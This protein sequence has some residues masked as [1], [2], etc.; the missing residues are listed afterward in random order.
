[1]RRIFAGPVNPTWA[2]FTRD[3]ASCVWASQPSRS[4]AV[5]CW[6]SRRQANTGSGAFRYE[7]M[8]HVSHGVVQGFH[9]IARPEAEQPFALGRVDEEPALAHLH[10]AGGEIRLASA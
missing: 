8:L 6:C 9:W 10:V 3:I 1:M 2:I 4:A 5:S 7:V